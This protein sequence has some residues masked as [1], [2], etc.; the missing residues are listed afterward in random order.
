[1]LCNTC[2]EIFAFDQTKVISWMKKNAIEIAQEHNLD[3]ATIRSLQADYDRY[4][5]A[6]NLPNTKS[7]APYPWVATKP[8]NSLSRICLTY[9]VWLSSKERRQWRELK[10]F[11]ASNECDVCVLLVAMIENHTT[12]TVCEDATLS[13]SWL[14][15]EGDLSVDYLQ[16]H[17]IDRNLKRLLL[18]RLHPAIEIGATS[19]VDFDEGR[20]LSRFH[21]KITATLF[22]ST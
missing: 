14:V 6:L 5:R 8:L 9:L 13:G 3:E 21:V 16:I 20:S 10:H 11:A 18:L 12:N 2:S 4:R 1:M 22:V 15:K 19:K 17:L 7:Q